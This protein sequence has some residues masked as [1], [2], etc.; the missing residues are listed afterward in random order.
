MR[1]SQLIA[2]DL[3]PWRHPAQRLNAHAQ[4]QLRVGRRKLPSLQA[5]TLAQVNAAV[6]KYVVPDK[7]VTV[8]AGTLPEAK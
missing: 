3:P 7:M 2:D 6:K 1:A 5:L 8:L 4:S